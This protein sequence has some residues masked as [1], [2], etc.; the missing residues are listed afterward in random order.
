MKKNR[1]KVKSEKLLNFAKTVAKS[2]SKP[3]IENFPSAR[4]SINHKNAINDWEFFMT[5]ASVHAAIHIMDKEWIDKYSQ[6]FNKEMVNSL[7]A[8]NEHS[9]KA[10][11]YLNIYIKDNL[12]KNVP[13]NTALGSWIFLNIIGD[14]PSLEE[15]KAANAIGGFLCQSL[16]GWWKET[17]PPTKKTSWEGPDFR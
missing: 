6:P 15:I 14:E 16:S 8:L 10:L 2:S 9:V 3:I 13:Y 5:V 4:A 11:S 7:N 12:K 17:S 1:L